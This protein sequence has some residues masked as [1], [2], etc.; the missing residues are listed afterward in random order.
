ME[1]LLIPVAGDL[2]ALELRGVREVLATPE[3]TPL[4]GAPPAVCGL[5]NL[6]GTI[7]PL[8]DTSTLLGLGRAEP[9]F[10]V[11]A[12]TAE[13]PAALTAGALPTTARLEDLAGPAELP[14]AVAR[15]AIADGGV[16]TLIDVDALMERLHA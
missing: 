5:F 13:G 3:L 7:V 16:A 12:D 2:Y 6:R 1:A 8:M 14:G 10:A 9:R 4:P 15:F 11:V